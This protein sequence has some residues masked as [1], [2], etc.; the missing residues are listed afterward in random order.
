MSFRSALGPPLGCRSSS[1]AGARREKVA[2]IISW[3]AFVIA[4]LE[5]RNGAGFPTG[6]R[7]GYSLG[8]V[9]RL[10]SVLSDGR[11]R[12]TNPRQPDEMSTIMWTSSSKKGVAHDQIG[13]LLT[14]GRRGT[15]CRG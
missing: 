7:C 12:P 3:R 13:N 10:F 14:A 8:H 15:Q 11:C 9:G 2:G 6:D 1:L 5:A 4:P